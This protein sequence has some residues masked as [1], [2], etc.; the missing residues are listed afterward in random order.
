MNGSVAWLRFCLT[1]ATVLTAAP[2]IAA[3]RTALQRDVEG[4]AVAVCLGRQ[5]SAYLKDQ[6]HG[7]ASTVVMGGRGE[8]DDLA[9]LQAAVEAEVARG[10]MAY[11]HRENEPTRSKAMPVM[12]C[13]NIIDRARVRGAIETAMKRMAP[14]YRRK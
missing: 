5:E 6:A 11:V 12:Y 2:A 1:L 4:Y 7:W 3:V 8:L 13:A 9:P 14:A 10:P